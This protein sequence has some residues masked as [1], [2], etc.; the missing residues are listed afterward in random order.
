MTMGLTLRRTAL[1]ISRLKGADYAHSF[2]LP[3]AMPLDPRLPG[4]LNANDRGHPRKSSYG[5]AGAAWS[6][7]DLASRPVCAASA[8]ALAKAANRSRIQNSSRAPACMDRALPPELITPNV[9]GLDMFV[10]GLPKLGVLK[11]FEV[12]RRSCIPTRS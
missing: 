4:A 9:E 1:R 10:P 6:N 12:S 3:A 8:A 5:V 7:R 2:R 11:K